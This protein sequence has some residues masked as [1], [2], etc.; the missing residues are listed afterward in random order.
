MDIISYVLSKRIA[1]GAVSGVSG[2]SVDGQTL[3]I[4][5]NDGTHLEMEF[6]TPEDGVSI[7]DVSVDS[8]KHLICT[9][10]DGTS[11][12]AGEVPTVKGDDGE[13]GADGEDGESAYE[14][15]VDEGYVGTKEE[16]LSSL[17]GDDG[18]S[19]EIVVKTSTSEQYIL[20]I[21][22]KEGSFDTPNLKGSG[23]EALA[24]LDDVQLTSLTTGQILK[25]DGTKWVNEDGIEIDSLGDINDVDL[26][27]LVDGQVLS[28]DA[29]NSKW[30]NADAVNPTQFETM[31]TASEY[32]QA[33]I[34]YIGADTGTYK[35]GYFYRSNPSVESG[36]VVYTWGQIDVQPSNSDYEQ[37]SNLP[38]IDSIEIIGNKSLDDFGIQGKV[39]F[40]TL[41]A[42]TVENAGKIVQYI[43]TT[44]AALKKG[45]FYQSAYDVESGDY[46]WVQV[47]V[48]SNSALESRL[49]TVEDNIGDMSTLEVVGVSDLV[50]A[51]NALNAKGLSTITYVEPNLVLTYA[52]GSV[53][54]FNVRD[55][56][57]DETQIGELA[58]VTDTAIANGNVLQYDSAILG[59]KPYDIG[60]ALTALL[61][62]AKDYTDQEIAGAVQDDAFIVDAKPVCS[63]DS[64]AD[65]YIVVY[66]QN[67]VVHTTTDTTARFYYKV[68]SDPYCTSWFVTGDPSVDPVEFTYLLS[69]PDFD[70][71]VN[72]NTD[73][74]SIYT[75][76][77]VDK[78][79]I[80][81]VAA[82]DA[83]MAIVN[84]ALALKINTSSIVD[85]LI[86]QDATKVLSANQGYVISGLIDD[87]NDQMQFT[88]M[89]SADS[90]LDG[91]VYQYVGTSSQAYTKGAF[92]TCTY[93]ED[94]DTWYWKE[95]E[96]APDM[97]AITTAEVDAL[98]A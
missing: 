87:K 39:Q 77:M 82:L 2:M 26:G 81:N 38:Q 85:S 18:F 79:K 54:R 14:I 70:D 30:V 32:P 44:T 64:G 84:T 27:T 4:E 56:I 98:W 33:V 28:W 15:A 66:Y 31:P 35:R 3:N 83:L 48:S 50:E 46:V 12:D 23:A 92:Y 97:V 52:D 6:P 62:S 19:P 69:T 57:L 29:T 21:T 75:T 45:Y 96:F 74:T 94:N 65:E 25:W 55:S 80:P 93:D 71:Y 68:S 13:P 22:T 34:Q 86:S 7:T 43:G 42:A 36:S 40:S 63:Y 9:M 49:D 61:N 47:D 88:T 53:I 91:V 72:K 24:D 10:S 41:P 8:S 58:N 73:V 89:P 16:W 67:G 51:A 59:Y 1:E 11:I 5:L 17:K 37:L 90:T 76:D 60:A 20:T 78:S 95:V